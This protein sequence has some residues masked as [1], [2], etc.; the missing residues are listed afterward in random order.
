MVMNMI[1]CA[2]CDD[3]PRMLEALTARL[4]ASLEERRLPF[5]V[6]AF[7]SGA[8]LL[9]RGGAFDLI[10]LDIQME[11][12]DGMEV[13]GKLRERGFRGFLIFITVLREL[14]FRSFEVQAYD[15]LVKPIEESRFEKTMERLLGSMRN[16]GE[17]SLLVQKG[18]ESRIV[19]REDIVYCEIIDRKVY[20]HLSSGE[21][22]DFYDRIEHLEARLDKGFFRCH[23]SFLINLKYLKSYKNGTAYLEGGVEI[24]VSRLRSREFSGVILEYMKSR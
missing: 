24:P 18:Y 2:I 14:V 22:L 3:E 15:Y 11:G 23:R 5:H 20:L 13:A 6:E 8:A 10:L 16:A 19:S 12:M 9:E 7:S 1:N 17:E 4:R 21:V